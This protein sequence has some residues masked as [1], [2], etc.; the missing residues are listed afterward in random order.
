M[1]NFN[2]TDKVMSRLQEKFKE[3]QQTRNALMIFLVSYIAD[4]QSFHGSQSNHNRFLHQK[5]SWQ[6]PKINYL[7]NSEDG[8]YWS[9]RN[10]AIVMGR[11]RSSI[12][13]TMNKMKASEEWNDKLS[14]LR[15]NVKSETGIDIEVY[16]QDIF[17][18]LLDYYEEEYL[19]RFAEP[20]YGNIESAPDINEIHRFWKHLKA[21]ECIQKSIFV[22]N[23]FV[24]GGFNVTLPI[25]KRYRYRII[26]SVWAMFRFFRDKFASLLRF[27]LPNIIK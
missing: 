11:N 13:R 17:D 15:K 21:M 23:P 7:F 8:F 19:L 5:Y 9:I 10:I 24:I 2:L 6:T 22:Q 1:T 20:R 14:S 12:T 3:F 4:Y 27:I 16:H 18:L 26:K 25:G